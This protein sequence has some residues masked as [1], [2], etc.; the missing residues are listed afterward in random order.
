[1]AKILPFKGFLPPA[2]LAELVSSPPYDTL[3][4]DEARSRTE[5]N[6]KSFL[7]VIK[8]EVDFKIG[9]EPSG[10]KLHEHAATNLSNYISNG[11]LLEDKDQYLYVYQIS[12][13][14]HVQTG[15]IAA[16]SVEEYDSGII[17]KHEYTR[18]EKEDDR[19]LHI[20]TTRANTGPVFLV[21]KNDGSFKEL[22]SRYA[23][24]KSII[25]FHA[26]DG[27]SHSIKKIENKSSIE[28]IRN[29]FKSVDNLYIA[30]GHHRAASASRFQK[31]Q[32]GNSNGDY[33]LG[34]LFPHDE[35]QILSYNRVVRRLD[36][37]QND[38]FFK[39]VK[40]YFSIVRSNKKKPND[41]GIFMM[42]LDGKWFALEAKEKIKNNDPVLGLD[43]S[44][45]QNFI[46]DLILNIK[47]PRT[48]S[49]LDFIGGSK[50]LDELERR[51]GMDAK[52]AFALYP[53]SIDDLLK[54]A[55]DGKVMPPK[56]T[57]FEPKLRSGLI[58]RKLD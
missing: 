16:V 13:G 28:N 2:S 17:K 58:V 4:S 47:D 36:G 35:V 43:A 55:D 12:M 37:F 24:E 48:D 49:R 10:R 51:C 19:T 53:V 42:Y 29:Y 8:P 32:N 56:S 27:S 41:K 52:I 30:D 15:I 31:S 26:D 45:L 57:W 7:R 9:T 38:L 39:E 25:Y 23:R 34:T 54:V 33:F 44:L 1:M 11:N 14:A 22:I 6:N 21:F 40:K 20:S 18:P 5:N 50:G 46:L 3:S